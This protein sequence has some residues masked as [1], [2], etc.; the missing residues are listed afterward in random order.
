ME[1]NE[2]FLRYFTVSCIGSILIVGLCLLSSFWNRICSARIKCIMW[3][4]LVVFLIVPV[5]LLWVE[6]IIQVELSSENRILLQNTISEKEIDLLS[7]GE[8]VEIVS[9]K[10]TIMSV[11]NEKEETHKGDRIL[12]CSAILWLLGSCITLCYGVIQYLTY[13]KKIFRWSKLIKSETAEIL[14]AEI[15]EEY[16]ISK[17]ISIRVTGDVHSPLMYGIIKP[18]IFMPN[19]EYTNLEMEMILRHELLHY[20][21]KDLWYKICLF[22]VRIVHWFNPFIY[23]MG[24]HA[25]AD[26]ERACDDN[27]LLEKG[28]EIR[29]EYADVILATANRQNYSHWSNYFYGGKALLKER[30]KNIL[31][32]RSRKNG[33]IPVVG[34]LVLI[35]GMNSLIGCNFRAEES[36]NIEKKEMVLAYAEQYVNEFQGAIAKEND[37]E[38]DD[39]IR[40]ENL[41][42]FTEKMI[43]LTQKQITAGAT[44]ALYGTDNEFYRKECSKIN[45]TVWYVDLYFVYRGSGQRCQMLVD[46]TGNM[47]ILDFYFGSMDGVDTICTGHLS[48]RTVKEPGLW[49]KEEWV[50]G[51]FEKMLEYEGML[52]TK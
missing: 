4:L 20:K 35:V 17:K 38:L 2:I 44:G 40:N 25:N 50:L 23:I 32:V 15:M 33:W 47:E 6:P 9:G 42:N 16:N 22:I 3:I 45:E 14:L 36:L 31:C 48:E 27:V 11:T 1:L 37:I 10:D 18:C 29:K 19:I 5:K 41:L 34:L 52:D 51:V 30:F 46:T 26:M 49:E 43:V 39:Y 24:K 13:K 8:S 7:I 28:I 21:R 12:H